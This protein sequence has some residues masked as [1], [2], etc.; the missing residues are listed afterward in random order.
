MLPD[1]PPCHLSRGSPYIS[2]FARSCPGSDLPGMCACSTCPQGS[3]MFHYCTISDIARHY[4]PLPCFCHL[5]RTLLEPP[6]R[7]NGPKKQ[8][9]S[10]I[11]SSAEIKNMPQN[12]ARRCQKVLLSNPWDD[13]P[14]V[15]DP[16]NRLAK[17]PTTQASAQ[18]HKHSFQVFSI[19]NDSNEF[20]WIQ[21]TQTKPWR[22]SSS[23]SAVL[24]PVCLG[25][26]PG[27]RWA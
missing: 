11:T 23:I 27:H 1:C 25:L 26:F 19:P 13:E 22:P 21:M 14:L 2:G 20:K 3:I 15:C 16:C 17:G 8:R 7:A 6:D 10:W 5:R 12:A 4:V 9:H 18:K 24:G